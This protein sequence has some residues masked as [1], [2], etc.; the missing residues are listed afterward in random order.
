VNTK[1]VN[2]EVETRAREPAFPAAVLLHQQDLLRTMI[3]RL[4]QPVFW[5]C[6]QNANGV[7]QLRTY[8]DRTQ[9]RRAPGRAPSACVRTCNQAF[10]YAIRRR[11]QLANSAFVRN[12]E[13]NGCKSRTR[14][15]DETVRDHLDAHLGHE[16]HAQH[17]LQKNSRFVFHPT[18]HRSPQLQCIGFRCLVNSS[19]LHPTVF[20]RQVRGKK[21]S[22]KV[23]K[24]LGSSSTHPLHHRSIC[25]AMERCERRWRRPK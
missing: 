24:L 20:L 11:A 16:E 25:Q 5:W 12:E 19:H 18:K 15:E 4:R 9:Q 17:L 22:R 2:G 10:A 13:G 14:V 1:P 8:A 7:A 3:R 6:S 21:V 23:D